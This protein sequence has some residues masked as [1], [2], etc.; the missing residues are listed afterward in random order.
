MLTAKPFFLSLVLLIAGA[1]PTLASEYGLTFTRDNRT[2]RWN[3]FLRYTGRAG[4]RIQTH[5]DGDLSKTLIK[6]ARGSVG[7]DR[8]QD[9]L[10]L[11][12]G[13][14]FR[15]NRWSSIGVDLSG[16]RNSVNRGQI[17]TRTGAISSL[18]ALTPRN[19]LALEGSLGGKL[20]QKEQSGLDSKEDGLSYGLSSAWTPS[21]A[22]TRGSLQASLSGDRLSAGHSSSRALSASLERRLFTRARIAL[23]Y[24]DQQ[25]GRT[26]LFGPVDDTVLKRQ[27]RIHRTLNLN[28]DIPLPGEGRF[29]LDL[30]SEDRR[31]EYSLPDGPDREVAKQNS[32]KTSQSL[33]ARIAGRPGGSWAVSGDFYL[34]EGKNDFGRDINDEDTE[35][36]ALGAS[37]S[38]DLSPRD[39]LHFSGHVARTSNDASHPDNYNDRD[40]FRSALK[41]TFAHAYS[42]ALQLQ[43]EAVANFIHLVYLRS[44]RSANNNWAKVY[45]LFPAVLIRPWD[46]LFIRQSFS[47]S[48]NYTE[49]D[50]E[51]LFT[52]IKSN[53]FRQARATTD[54]N[55]RLG[56]ELSVDLSYTY[57]VEDFGRLIRED[58]WV[59]ILSWDKSYQNVD[60]SITYPLFSRLT[61]SPNLGYSHRREYD[62][63][64]GGRRFRS[65][66]LSKRIGLSGRYRLWPDNDM[67]FSASRSVENATDLPERIFDRLQL[68]LQHVF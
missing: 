12:A 17:I 59:E 13:F 36:I 16:E 15:L 22:Q 33:S 18:L 2:Y 66:L 1:F 37:L 42:D 56:E 62:H 57:R 68:S 30:S 50:F 31:I 28:A 27:D 34:E 14:D 49:Y 54:L 25:R 3:N 52:D 4:P 10:D 8:W 35:E 45:T 44:Q 20:D 39:S 38:G 64:Q 7:S 5:A 19:D 51:D 24:D 26:N 41:L 47:I 58:D 60:F 63:L 65:R 9:N 32:R 21:V 46:D 67:I 11:S 53:I 61:V 55:Y 48:A 40:T 43:I 6:A 23:S 29:V